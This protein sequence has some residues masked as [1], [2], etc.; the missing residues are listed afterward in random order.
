VLVDLKVNSLSKK[1]LG[2]NTE[3]FKNNRR[4]KSHTLSGILKLD[5]HLGLKGLVGIVGEPKT[6]KSTF[7]LQVALHNVRQG[8]PVLWVD[9]EN[10]EHEST[11]RVMASYYHKS[12]K[13]LEETPAEE[14]DKLYKGLNKLPLY[15]CNENIEFDSLKEDIDLMIAM[16]P[17]KHAVLV[18]DSLQSLKKNL[19]DIRLSIDEW[20]LHLDD[21]KLKYEDRITIFFICEKRRGT[22]GEATIDSGK[23]SGRIEYKVSQQLDFRYDRES[24]DTILECTLNRHGPRGF[25][26]RL[27]PVLDN[28]NE[29]ES[30]LFQLKERKIL[31]L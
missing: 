17:D 31:D 5:K 25:R 30:F 6:C 12:L 27:Q 13:T 23:E 28:P 18:I 26:V 10:G 21:I 19:Q 16:H 15:Y 3:L 7:A 29:P 22:Y 14:Y 1:R 20:L 24:G 2:Q 8:N 4:A 9:R 11:D